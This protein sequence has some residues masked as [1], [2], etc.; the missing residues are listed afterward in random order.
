M[1]SP[2]GLSVRVAFE[3]NEAA[4]RLLNPGFVELEL[5]TPEDALAVIVSSTPPA[6]G[7]VVCTIVPA[8][9]GC[10]PLACVLRLVFVHCVRLCNLQLHSGHA[11]ADKLERVHA[12][13]ASKR[14]PRVLF[15]RRTD[16]LPPYICRQPLRELHVP[17]GGH[18]QTQLASALDATSER[19]VR[20]A[21]LQA[22]LSHGTLAETLPERAHTCCGCDRRCYRR[23]RGRALHCE[24]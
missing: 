13:L 17:T 20:V 7:S 12:D 24:E 4:A 11:A 10:A 14:S 6:S 1:L 22:R 18:F 15:A 16:A 23:R 5:G 21:T 9:D 3:S 2:D 19:V 8:D